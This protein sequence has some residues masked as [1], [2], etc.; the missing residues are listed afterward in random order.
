MLNSPEVLVAEFWTGFAQDRYEIQIGK[1][2]L[3]V[4]LDRI[5]PKLAEQFIRS[6]L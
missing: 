2:K 6:G 4:M 5:M 3:L 1:T